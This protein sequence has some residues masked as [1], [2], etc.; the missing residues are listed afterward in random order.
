MLCLK[1]MVEHEN[2]M[3]W[4]IF[5]NILKSSWIIFRALRLFHKE[6]DLHNDN[7]FYRSSDPFFVVTC[8]DCG[9]KVWSTRRINE[10]CSRCGSGAV[11]TEAPYHTIEEHKGRCNEKR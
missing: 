6:T 7:N 5:R 10:K 8:N 1:Q 9:R 2:Y 11:K 4:R 3:L